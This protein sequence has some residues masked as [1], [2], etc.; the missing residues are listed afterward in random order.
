VLLAV[1]GAAVVTPAPAYVLTES[2]T[3]WNGGASRPLVDEWAS[4]TEAGRPGAAIT[5][6]ARPTRITQV[7]KDGRG[8][9]RFTV[10]ARDRDRFTS[11]AQRTE[12]AQGNPARTF[13]DGTGSRNMRPGDDRWVAER[14]L[15]PAAVVTGTRGYFF[16]TLNQFKLDGP[17]GPTAALGFEDNRL[18]VSRAASRASGTAQ[19]Q[20]L[21]STDVVP[22]DRW[23]KILWHVKWSRTDDGLIDVFTDLGGGFQPIV[24]Y[25][26]WTLKR[27]TTASPAR[28]HPRIG[29]YRR[30]IR[31][32]TRVFISDFNVATSRAKAQTGAGFRP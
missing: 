26:G 17:G 11:D 19:Q 6:D 9:Y 25:R 31:R 22:R 3:Q 30:A 24:R 12:L 1:D 18:V 28:V 32:N 10:L 14:I 4:Y 29:I 21:G 7:I 13:A 5:P 2:Q 8:A 16:F 15:I 20:N 27:R 23:I